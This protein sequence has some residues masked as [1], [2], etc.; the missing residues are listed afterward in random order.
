MVGQTDAVPPRHDNVLAFDAACDDFARSWA[1]ALGPPTRSDLDRDHLVALLGRLT[2]QLHDALTGPAYPTT[3]VHGVGRALVEHGFVSVT[4]LERSIAHV[5]TCLVPAFGLPDDQAAH[6]MAVLGGIAAGYAE[7][8][9]EHT[10]DSTEREL[11]HTSRD[12]EARFRA[13]FRASGVAIV[14]T[15]LDGGLREFNDALL[16]LLGYDDA[17]TLAATNARDLFHLNDQADLDSALA[18]LAS[19]VREHVRSEKRMLRSDGEVVDVLVGISLVRDEGT[20]AYHVMLVEN[21]DEVR[22]LQHQL[23]RQSLRDPHTGLANRAQ[24]LGWVEGAV[25]GFGPTTAALVVFDLD[26]F[27]VVNDAFG[28]ETGNRVLIE[29]A[30]H[31]RSVF[32]A[33]GRVA[34]IGADEF[35][36]LVHDPTDVATVVA[37]VEEAIDLFSE[38]LWI[39]D[40]GIGV[41]ASVGIVV[42]QTRG[43]DPVELLRRATVTLGWAKDEGKA[44]WALYDPARDDREQELLRLAASIAGG[45]EQDEFRV[46]YEPVYALP[47]RTV[48]AVETRLRWDHPVLGLLD[49]TTMLSVLSLATVTGMVVRLG[50][51]VLERAC[52]DAGEWYRRFGPA[53]PVLTMD[54]TARQCQEPELVAEVRR[55]LRAAELPASLLQFELGESVPTL[56]SDDQAEE[57]TIL[58]DDGVRLVLAQISDTLPA[59]R[60]RRLPVSGIKVQGIPDPTLP[61]TARRAGLALHACGITTEDEAAALLD[62]GVTAAQGPLFGPGP[63]D[64][65]QVATILGES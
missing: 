37:Q 36:V 21:L 18:T 39:G 24:F 41:A 47:S 26:G 20:P 52:S 28:H 22:A 12:S 35:G 6:L 2:E 14:I 33:D 19:G 31:L 29:V 53:A 5:G 54:L 59:D 13:L 63:L 61:D 48:V 10:F 51:W 62:L 55:A 40:Y 64:A 44:Q 16:S 7:A 34:R 17:T 4:A 9:R 3:T 42:A 49:T 11:R 43:A 8:S 23:L 1:S 65:D 50:R 58:T 32:G 56:V 25:G 30:N 27:R 38:A 45:L 46:D 57:L 60:L 15:G